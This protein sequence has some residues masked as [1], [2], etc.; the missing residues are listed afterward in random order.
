MPLPPTSVIT[1]ER[2]IIEQE[3]LHPQATGDLSGLLYD[4]ALAAKMISLKVRS[5]GL[6]DIIGATEN[7]NVQGEVQ[8][9]LDVLANEIII[10]ALD[11][12]GRLC[13]MG[14]EEVEGPIPIP[15]RFKQGRYAM[16]FDPLDGSSNIDVNTSI[17]TIFSIHRKVSSGP[18]GTEEDCLQVGSNQVAAGYFIYGSS[19]MMVYTTGNGVHGFTLDQALGEFILSHEN[20]ST[21]EQGRIYSVNEGNQSKWDEGTRQ[22]IEH[23]KTPDEAT[24]R[25]YSMRY[26]GSLVADFHR[27][28]L[29]GGIFMYPGPKAKLRLLYEA[30]PLAMVAEQAGGLATTGTQ[31]ILDVVPTGL[32]M[33]VPLVIGSRANVEEY[34]EFAGAASVS[35]GRRMSGTTSAG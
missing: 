22:Y 15:S 25:P 33:R 23:L 16:L 17:G 19:T 34:L 9:K 2:F 12:S 31:S 28:L 26:I 18:D 8:Q 13:V 20:I 32:H 30:A 29:K 10:K 6:A 1:I 35:A 24:G 7:E 11:H 27:N 21:P 4:L 5:A 14:S 3:Q